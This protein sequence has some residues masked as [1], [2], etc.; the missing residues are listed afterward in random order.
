MGATETALAAAEVDGCWSLEKKPSNI[1][2]LN[3]FFLHTGSAML[4]LHELKSQGVVVIPA[5]MDDVRREAARSGRFVLGGAVTE[6][7]V[8]VLVGRRGGMTGGA[9]CASWMRS[10]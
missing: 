9:S 4:M 5:T 3:P 1:N 8:L 6:A 7:A 2:S 10:T